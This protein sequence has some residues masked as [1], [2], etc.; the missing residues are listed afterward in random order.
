M[1]D[2]ANKK[3]GSFSVELFAEKWSIPIIDHKDIFCHCNTDFRQ[4]EMSTKYTRKLQAPFIEVEDQSR[5]YG[6]ELVEFKCF[7]FN[8]MDITAP[9]SCSPFDTWY[10]QNSAANNDIINDKGGQ[11]NRQY[12]CELCG[13]KYGELQSHL[14]TAEHKHAAMDNSCYAGVDVL[15][16]RGVSLKD[17]VK[18]RV[19]VKNSKKSCD[20]E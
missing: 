12:F 6:P 14:D 17:F 15:I 16:K 11:Q 20:D 7:P 19:K 2:K 3:S 10:K 13:E 5:R 18:R 9:M 1:I 4:Q 8:F